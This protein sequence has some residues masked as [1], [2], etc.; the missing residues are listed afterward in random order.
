MDFLTS[1]AGKYRRHIIDL[2][3]DKKK[4]RRWSPPVYQ[5]LSLPSP[6]LRDVSALCSYAPVHLQKLELPH[7]KIRDLSCISHML[8]LVILDAS[9]NEISHCFE[10]QP[11]R[12]LQEVNLSYN[13][14]SEMK[15]LAA[16]TYLCKL[17]LDCNSFSEIAGLE[18]CRRLRHLSVANNNLWR[19][20]GL[21]GLPLTHLCLRGNQLRRIEG[22]EN[23][24]SLQVLDLSLNRITSLSGLQNL[25][26]LVS[27]N[28]EN[29]QI[30][31]IQECKHIHHLSLVKDLSLTGNPVQEQLDYRLA[32]IFLLQHVAVLDQ[33]IVTAEEKVSSV[34][35]FDPPMEVVAAGDH[36]TQLVYQ[37][38]QP[39]VIYD[40]STPPSV[41]TPYPMLVLTGPRGCGKRELVHRLCQEF[42]KLF[43]YGI[44]HTTRGP[45]RGEEDGIDYRFV[46]EDDFQ[47]MIHM[48]KFI[49]T[50]QYEGHQFGLSRDSVEGLARDGLAC[51]THM[52]LEGVLSLKKTY[53]EPQYILLLP[54]RVET[55]KH[56]LEN[57]GI[58]T[59]AQIDE[60]VSRLDL[61]ARINTQRPGFIDKIIPCDDWEDAYR[62]LRQTVKEYLLVDGDD[63]R[64]DSRASLHSPDPEKKPPSQRLGSRPGSAC[65][66]RFTRTEAKPR[67]EETPAERAS[68][69][70][71]EQL[72]REALA[73][74]GP[75]IGP[76][77]YSQLF[78]RSPETG[79]PSFPNKD[80]GGPGTLRPERSRAQQQHR[81]SWAEFR[82]SSDLSIPSSAGA[83]LGPLDVSILGQALETLKDDVASSRS[84]VAASPS[85]ER[86]PG[87]DV[88]AVLPPIP[89]GHKSPTPP[90][91]APSPGLSPTP[92]AGHGGANTEG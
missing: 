71:R 3:A 11:P 34:N 31:E 16:C 28:L 50:M 1:P 81:F 73:G 5:S 37:M 2:Y 19:I 10:F 15:D 72:L 30:H 76:G 91:L 24:K 54:T 78:K 43:G 38:L 90:S 88:K 26:R 36:M 66:P 75:G 64:N 77:V 29:N 53:F 25:D 59:P 89:T 67:P 33:E 58:Y 84:S 74:I 61:Y 62:T 57:R 69:R 7:K 51:C 21:D 83:L 82:S 13:L 6:N 46:S 44:C 23:V 4:E 20:S 35:K 27:V 12:K 40:S 9:H 22:L 80:P 45:Y 85:S 60:A 8:N 63:G 41:E 86:R 70:T 92:P 47:H 49:Q 39:Q 32:V 17:D 56:H 68:L 42:S 55:Y 52:E 65:V 87:S 79:Q 18:R 14:M 48:G